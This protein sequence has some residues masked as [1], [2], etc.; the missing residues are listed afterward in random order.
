MDEPDQLRPAI[1]EALAMDTVTI[2]QVPVQ[3]GG[4]GRMARSLGD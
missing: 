4:I 3:Q 2:I 1:E